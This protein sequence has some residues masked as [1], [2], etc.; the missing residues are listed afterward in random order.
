MDNM[1]IARKFLALDEKDEAVKA[2][3]LA[4]GECRGREP[5]AEFECALNILQFGHGEDYKISFRTMAD[6]FN[7]KFAQA[8]IR[9][10]MKLAFYQPHARELQKCYDR[11]CRLL[12]R[13]PYIFRK[14]F[15]DFEALPIKFYPYAADQYMLFDV[16]KQVFGE[17]FAPYDQIIRHNFYIDLENPV[18]VEDVF[19]QNELEYLVDNVRRNEWLARKNKI[20]LH[21]TAWPVFCAYLQVWDLPPLLQD[22]K[23]V[24]LI[25]DDI[26]RYNVAPF[27]RG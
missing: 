25:E 9:D 5:R 4:L 10:I 1:E 18:L 23:I 3:K 7:R 15:P 16:E 27:A 14:D 20:Y 26:R 19:S 21:Y 22:E 6:L 8:E 13:Y 17:L 11:N 12:A 2:Y 24:W